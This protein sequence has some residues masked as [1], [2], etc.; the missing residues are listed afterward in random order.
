MNKFIL[1]IIL[2]IVCIVIFTGGILLIVF[3]G[4]LSEKDKN[5]KS[6]RAMMTWGAILQ[7]LG[8]IVGFLIIKEGLSKYDR[9]GNIKAVVN[10]IRGQ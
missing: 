9:H 2:L 10:P 4:K 7:A 1:F 6:S 8:G 3:G 5:S